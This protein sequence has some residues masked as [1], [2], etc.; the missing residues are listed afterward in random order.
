MPERKQRRKIYKKKKKGLK[1]FLEVSG[2]LFLSFFLLTAGLFIYY[3]KD[4]PRPEKFTEGVIPQSTKIYDRT[5]EVLLYE[6]AGE[7]KRTLVSL[8]EIP[9]ELKLAVIATEDKNFYEHRG[10]DLGAIF[11]AVLIDLELGEPTHGG[12]TLTQQ[13]IR[14]YFLTRNKTLE[15]KTRELNSE[16]N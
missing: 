5:G 14:S 2:I 12:S 10:L 16:L 9:K 4:L 8:E 3:M 13:L 7:E 6:I 15:R 1:I 11:R